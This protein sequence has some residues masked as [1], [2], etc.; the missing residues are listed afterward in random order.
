ML[1]T[2]PQNAKPDSPSPPSSSWSDPPSVTC[3]SYD[4]P[5]TEDIF[6][7]S[8]P[9][10]PLRETEDTLTVSDSSF[11]LPSVSEIALP[12]LRQDKSL[13]ASPRTPATPSS[14]YIASR[15]SLLGRSSS[16]GA[17]DL[18]D[19]TRRRRP[20]LLDDQSSLLR[21]SAVIRARTS[22]PLSDVVTS[23][24]SPPP[25]SPSTPPFLPYAHPRPGKI[26]Q[27]TGD[28]SAQAFHNAKQAQANLPWY[29][30]HQHSEEEIKVEFDG[31]VK[32]GTLPALVERLVVDPLREDI[33]TASIV[34]T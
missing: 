14:S 31:T 11:A 19:R 29:L 13:P 5:V 16:G 4:I 27:L 7:V 26:L 1:N 20:V 8:L 23:P 30:K 3:K 21:L 6:Q 18:Q 9:N 17:A 22:D 28:D 10:S 12:P 33:V 15:F 34:I 24:K 2:V 32:A 25:P